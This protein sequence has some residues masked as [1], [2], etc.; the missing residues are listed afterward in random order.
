ML[1]LPLFLQPKALFLVISLILFRS[2]TRTTRFDR[3]R[4]QASGTP[5][6]NFLAWTLFKPT[7]ASWG[8]A[9]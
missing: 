6:S 8:Y 2:F 9:S 1:D 4:T 3:E 7:A 5:V